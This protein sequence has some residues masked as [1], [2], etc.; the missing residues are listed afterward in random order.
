MNAALEFH[1]STLTG[2][3]RRGS[4]LTVVLNPAYIHKFEQ[5]DGTEARTGWNHTVH[6][7]VESGEANGNLSSLP[8]ELES[9]SLQ[10]GDTPYPHLV[11]V[12]LQFTGSVSL[13]LTCLSGHSLVVVGRAITV[14]LVGA[15]KYV[16]RVPF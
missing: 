15:G 5:R 6:L 13:Q 11:P 7:T 14:A 10:C 3:E 16:E 9:G 1:D 8:E 12:P 2:I 4:F